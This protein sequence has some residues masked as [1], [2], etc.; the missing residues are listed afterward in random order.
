MAFVGAFSSAYT[1]AVRQAWRFNAAWTT[2][3]KAAAEA[4][5]KDRGR[6]LSDYAHAFRSKKQSARD[7]L[8]ARL[9]PQPSVLDFS[10]RYQFRRGYP[11]QTRA[12]PTQQHPWAWGK[13]KPGNGSRAQQTPLHDQGRRAKLRMLLLEAYMG[14]ALR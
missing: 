7:A 8:Q 6:T 14:R 13:S 5:T 10:L 11:S 12:V 4:A 2:A 3:S 1:S 9:R